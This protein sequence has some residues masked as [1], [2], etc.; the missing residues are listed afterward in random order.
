MAILVPEPGDPA[1]ELRT[2]LPAA[3]MNKI[4]KL[5]RWYSYTTDTVTVGLRYIDGRVIYFDS[6]DWLSDECL[7]LIALQAP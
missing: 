3:L 7:S 5:G 2:M 1:V 4:T 6:C